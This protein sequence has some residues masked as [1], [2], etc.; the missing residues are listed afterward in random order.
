MVHLMDDEDFPQYLSNYDPPQVYDPTLADGMEDGGFEGFF[1]AQNTLGSSSM[2]LRDDHATDLSGNTNKLSDQNTGHPHATGLVSGQWTHTPE[3]STSS[4]SS[5]QHQRTDS[6]GSSPEV[7]VLS[8]NAAA[9]HDGPG[10]EDVLDEE[11]ANKFMESHFD[12]DSAASSPSPALLGARS[13]PVPPQ[14]IPMAF[15]GTG[16][17]NSNFRYS[18]GPVNVSEVLLLRPATNPINGE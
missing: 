14:G 5:H 17:G 1:E 13:A 8:Q 4:E 16:P 15:R 9:L 10:S 7:D 11:A 18:P 2:A 12:F 3:S 6:S